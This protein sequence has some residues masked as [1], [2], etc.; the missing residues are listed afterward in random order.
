MVRSEAST[1]FG[2][3]VQVKDRLDKY[4]AQHKDEI[5]TKYK[6]KRRLVTNSDV[7]TFLL[8]KVRK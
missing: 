8:D 2:I 7:I 5:I 3:T 6:K 1:Q 4:K